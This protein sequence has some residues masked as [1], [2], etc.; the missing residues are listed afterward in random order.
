LS[1]FSD[2]TLDIAEYFRERE[3]IRFFDGGAT[4]REAHEG[5]K[6]DVLRKFGGG[7]GELGD[8]LSIIAGIE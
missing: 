2:R 8:V 4:A 1:E 7:L 6:R 5:A 3:A